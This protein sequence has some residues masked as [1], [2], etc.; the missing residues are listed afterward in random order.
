[1]SLGSP[2]FL[3][4]RPMAPPCT[5]APIEAAIDKQVGDG[6]GRGRIALEVEVEVG[7]DQQGQ[8]A[9]ETAKAEGGE[10]EHN[11]Q[12]AHLGLAERVRP[13]VEVRAR[14]EP[15]RNRAGGFR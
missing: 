9:F 13:L 3:T 10:E 12:E 6:A 4:S 14:G 2:I 11:D 5:S 15:G 1:M 7:A 8:R